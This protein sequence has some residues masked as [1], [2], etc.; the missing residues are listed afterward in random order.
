MAG[1]DY[2]DKFERD[3]AYDLKAKD[4]FKDVLKASMS[5]RTATDEGLENPPVCAV[6]GAL[7]EG[8]YL[9]FREENDPD[10]WIRVCANRVWC[11]NMKDDPPDPDEMRSGNAW[12]RRVANLYLNVTF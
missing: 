6:C 9:A 7:L 10:T 3:L 4:K 5:V 11:R 8:K 2:M 1:K 12:F